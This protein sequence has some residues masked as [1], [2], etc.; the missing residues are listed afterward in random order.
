[1]FNTTFSCRLMMVLS[2]FG[3][4]IPPT[5]ARSL[6]G[7]QTAGVGPRDRASKDA[8]GGEWFYT[9][10]AQLQ[11]PIGLP[12]ELQVKG[13]A[14]SDFGAIGKTDTS[15]GTIDDASSLRG[16]VGFGFSWESP[17]GPFTIDFS[18]VFLKESFDQ[19]ESIRFDLGTR[20]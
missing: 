7:F 12:S 2:N 1:M 5:L 14:F 4:I 6:R 8:V 17:V 20:F 10:S 13:R 9:A 19:T 15:L 11:F 18:K 3:S 16:A